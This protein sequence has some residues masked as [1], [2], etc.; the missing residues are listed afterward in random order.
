MRSHVPT[1]RLL[2]LLA[3]VLATTACEVSG[4]IGVPRHPHPW[5]PSRPGTGAGLNAPVVGLSSD[6]LGFAVHARDF[7]SDQTYGPTV[8][9]PGLEVGV[10]LW[11]YSGGAATLEVR[12][13]GGR[14][15]LTQRLSSN[16]A[17][18]NA[19]AR[20]APPFTIRLTFEHFSGDLSLGV[21]SS[22]DP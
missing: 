20:G 21:G 19:A 18:G 12:D 5:V 1:L 2:T 4:S 6:G 16:I 7:S 14:V 22:G 13:A 15:V 3:G 17:Q 9:T 8:Y 11:G 10:A